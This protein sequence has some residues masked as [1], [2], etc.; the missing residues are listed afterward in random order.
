[1][2]TTQGLILS[3]VAYPFMLAL[4]PLGL[5]SFRWAGHDPAQIPLEST[6][7]RV[8][9]YGTLI[10]LAR[11]AISGFFSG[12]GRTRIIMFANIA[13]LV[14]NTLLAW[15]LIFGRFGAPQ[16]G[17]SGAALALLTGETVALLIL[18]GAYLTPANR[19]EFAVDRAWRF[20]REV[21]WRLLRFGSPSG[22]ELCINLTAFT[23]MIFMFHGY[24]EKT[25]SA[26]T[27]A[28]NW[29]MV[30]FVPMIGLQI[31]VMSLVGQN[32]GAGD[33]AGAKRAAWSGMKLIV[34]YS[35]AMT[36][37]FL[38]ATDTLIGVF[39]PHPAPA[40]FAEIARMARVMIMLMTV[41]LFSDGLFIVFS[42]AIR[43]A[44][45]T[46]WAMVASA[47]LHWGAALNVWVCTKW[48]RLDPVHAWSFYVLSFP[49]FG[50][51]FWLRFR[52]G[53]WQRHRL[54][55]TTPRPPPA[56]EETPAPPT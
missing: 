37:L 31:A 16:M 22:L 29:D 3:V 50:L 7:F 2:S 55:G 21:M 10:M 35:G 25:A 30:A 51:V 20:D 46:T 12:I 24:G 40:D 44:G 47:L 48:L 8:L 19:A 27:I 15:M 5:A 17:M 36:L 28:F 43:G 1:M 6:Y 42:G 39:R 32:M 41:Y 54:A 11:S 53:K 14:V 18:L 26:V 4:I 34:F 45:D 23:S 9:M 56:L 49:V 38:L 33:V 52:G 13:A